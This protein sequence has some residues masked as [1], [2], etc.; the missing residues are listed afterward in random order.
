MTRK[1]QKLTIGEY[2]VSSR[3]KYLAC[4]VYIPS[5][6]QNMR[7]MAFIA[8]KLN[9]VFSHT[10]DKGKPIP[11]H[12]DCTM[13]DASSDY[14]ASSG[15]TLDAYEAYIPCS[16]VREFL[17]S[18]FVTYF[19]FIDSARIPHGMGTLARKQREALPDEISERAA[20][21]SHTAIIRETED[22]ALTR[23][24]ILEN[25]GPKT[26]LTQT[27][28]T[29]E[30]DYLDSKKTATTWNGQDD[31]PVDG[32]TWNGERKYIFPA[33]GTYVHAYPIRIGKHV[34]V[35]DGAGI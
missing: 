26:T 2:G 11:V 13:D 28:K 23:R 12:P 30:R 33:Q 5:P 20:A 21:Q 34:Y 24:T 22:D 35:A 17:E 32:P 29:R 7:D 9:V 16:K 10:D 19:H 14:I 6:K 4:I 1:I 31:S 3:N 27:E 15:H 18:S 25:R 8:R